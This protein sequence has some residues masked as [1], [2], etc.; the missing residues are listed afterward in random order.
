MELSNN[1]LAVVEPEI[2]PTEIKIDA[3]A[4]EKNEKKE[5]GGDDAEESDFKQTSV[6]ATLAPMVLIN[7]YQFKPSD[8][9][10]FELNLTEILPTCRLTL[11]DQEGKFGV[12]SIPRDGDFFT[13]LINSKNQETF[14]SIHMDF[15]IAE[16]D[17]PKEG[18]VADATYTMS[19]FCKIPRIYAEDC[20]SFGVAS[21]LDHMELIARDLQLGLATNIDSTDD[22][23]D[24]LM[25][26][27]PYLDFI[28]STIKESYIGEESF[29]KFWID[30][31]YYM[32]YVDVNALFNSPNPPIEEF[33]ESLASTVESMTPKRDD[34]TNAVTGNDI[35]VP[36]LLTNHIAF[37]GNSAFIE[38][39]KIINNANA[40]STTA[41][42]A[43]EVT[44]YDNN[45]DKA[46]RK[47]EFRIE[48]LGGNDLKELEEPLRGN[49]NDTRH[50]DQIKYKYIGRQ[51][52]GADGL[53]NVH[54]NAAFSQLHNTQ[55]ELET[56]KMKVEVT[57]NS[58]NPSLYKYQKI[59]VLMY[60]TNPKAI[61]QNER[62][63][64]DKKELGMDQ[65]EPFALG[66][67][68]EGIA[69]SGK[70]SPSQ[71]LDTFLSGYYL[72]EDIVYRTE[73][74]ETKQIVTLLRREWPTRTENLINPPGLEEAPVEE[75]A[76]AVA[77]NSPPPPEPTPAPT[78]EPTPVPEPEIVEPVEP[79]LDLDLSPITKG[80]TQLGSWYQLDLR[81]LWTADDISLVTETPS[82]E[83]KFIGAKEVVVDGNV[84][85]SESRH[86]VNMFESVKYN[87]T[88]VLEK[89]TL[90]DNE[91]D[92]TIEV[93]LTYKDQTVVKTVPFKSSP[94]T[95]PK[96]LGGP[97]GIRVN[98]HY[99][100]MHE[101]GLS[102]EYG[103]FEGKYTLA[104]EVVKKAKGKPPMSGNI[105]GEDYQDL[106]S[107][108][109]TAWES[110]YQSHRA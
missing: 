10:F 28:K 43:R 34:E 14:K 38:S 54:P 3:L 64:G 90:K 67:D 61:Q 106:K 99:I 7:G 45:S 46:E 84:S 11:R 80:R 63:K 75:K 50:V 16:C 20:K 70:E 15:D 44:I 36:L 96:Q 97:Q 18:N 5:T 89:A 39:N 109:K 31:Y 76:E 66:E 85:M 60:I 57:L 95:G 104:S 12:G 82:V 19:G 35:E 98:K 69:E 81:A 100:F 30:S 92:Y 101:V 102:S 56:Q 77:E 103:V 58:F 74:G 71:A 47:Q 29:Q 24:R 59:P 49:R 94:W 25:S 13:I 41:G 72:I 21:S 88:G 33:A 23:Q 73:E 22:E 86:N 4:E 83:F 32:N 65:D 9:E 55:N 52:A 87:I 40:I 51:E 37:M 107:R 2:R 27:E 48:P 79:I 93:T 26:F 42:Y 8:V 6:I 62:I 105:T 91:G 110:E 53:G 78:P 1:I 17:S 108:T 68:T